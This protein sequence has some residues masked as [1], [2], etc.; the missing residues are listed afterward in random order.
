[1]KLSRRSL[2]F[3]VLTEEEGSE[4][5]GKSSVGFGYVAWRG[6]HVEGLCAGGGE[7]GGGSEG[8]EGRVV[9]EGCRCR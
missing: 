7:G 8:E 9:R 2:G 6:L 1:M 4:A 5:S 3:S